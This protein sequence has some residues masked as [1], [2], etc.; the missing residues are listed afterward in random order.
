[1]WNWIMIAA[2]YTVSMG[3]L[4]LLGGVRSA[5]DALRRWGES[6]SRHDGAPPSPA[7]D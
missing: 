1:M 5:G 6:A 7:S 4:A 3:L 2:L